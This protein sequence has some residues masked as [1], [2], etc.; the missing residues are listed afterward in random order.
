MKTPI[1]PSKLDDLPAKDY[2]IEAISH[3]DTAVKT[4]SIA[5]GAAK[6]ILYSIIEK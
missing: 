2:F 6:G 1:D 3:V 5:V 4:S